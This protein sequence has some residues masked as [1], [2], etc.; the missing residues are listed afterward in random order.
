LGRAAY[1]NTDKEL[2][3]YGSLASDLVG[4][5]NHWSHDDSQ[6]FSMSLNTMF[7]RFLDGTPQLVRDCAEYKPQYIM[8]CIDKTTSDALRSNVYQLFSYM[9]FAL[10]VE[11]KNCERDLRV[12]ETRQ[13]QAGADAT[14]QPDQIVTQLPDAFDLLLPY[15][16]LKTKGR[17]SK[18]DNRALTE[19]ERTKRTSRRKL[20]NNYDRTGRMV[21]DMI[22]AFGAGVLVMQAP[23][24]NM[25]SLLKINRDNFDRVMAKLH[26]SEC[27]KLFTQSVTAVLEAAVI[28]TAGDDDC[29][30]AISMLQDFAEKGD[31]E[32]LRLAATKFLSKKVVEQDSSTVSEEVD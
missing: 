18:A 28:G 22:N 30:Q 16:A 24:M 19:Q 7:A 17:P 27:F 4:A 11:E 20:L 2:E 29:I 9:Q 6:T 3:A 1:I 26:Q 21:I 15:V 13:L 10:W 5:L 12:A 8:Q 31:A 23:V 32:S 25:K 14:T